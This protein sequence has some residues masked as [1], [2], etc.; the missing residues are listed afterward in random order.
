MIQKFRWA[1]KKTLSSFEAADALRDELKAAGHI[2]KVRRCGDGGTQFKVVVGTE[3]AKNNKARKGKGKAKAK[4][5][6]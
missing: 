4:E 5:V 3:I 1:Q 2:V 6:S